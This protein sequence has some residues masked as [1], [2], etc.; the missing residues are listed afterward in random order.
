MCHIPAPLGSKGLDIGTFGFKAA[1]IGLCMMILSA[2][3]RDKGEEIQRATK[4]SVSIGRHRYQII[5]VIAGLCYPIAV[6]PLL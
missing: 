4:Y 3:T 5:R 6:N 1:Q 2:T